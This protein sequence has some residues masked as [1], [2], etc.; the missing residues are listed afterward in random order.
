MIRF[1]NLKDQI[2]E[3]S[4]DFAFYDTVS[5]T[6][7]CFSG[8]QVFDSVEDFKSCFKFEHDEE[9]PIRPLSRFIDLIPNDFFK[10]IK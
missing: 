10:R 4:N 7:L 1:L 6:I 9:D 5:N 8:E 2:D 3:G